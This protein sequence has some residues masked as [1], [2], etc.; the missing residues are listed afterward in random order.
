MGAWYMLLDRRFSVHPGPGRMVGGA[1]G[2]L[3]GRKPFSIVAMVKSWMAR[4]QAINEL[5]A[6]DD[7]LLHDIGISRYEIPAIVDGV[8]TAAN[9][10]RI[11]PAPTKAPVGTDEEVLA[12]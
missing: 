7:R 1:M 3:A 5:E 2:N 8:R 11:T 12:A 6:L 10:H 4:R 9:I